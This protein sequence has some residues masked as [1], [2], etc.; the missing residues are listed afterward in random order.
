METLAAYNCAWL[1]VSLCQTLV[2]E[3]KWHL[4]FGVLPPQRVPEEK[5]MST[6]QKVTMLVGLLI[7]SY[8]SFLWLRSLAK[9]VPLRKPGTGKLR[10]LNQI[11][12]NS[13]VLRCH[14]P[15]VKKI[16]W[17]ICSS[18]GI[19]GRVSL[20][21]G[22]LAQKEQLTSLVSSFL[23][24]TD[25]SGW[26]QRLTSHCVVTSCVVS[27]YRKNKLTMPICVPCSGV[28]CSPWLDQ[29]SRFSLHACINHVSFLTLCQ[30]S[31]I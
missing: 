5:L 22:S 8:N 25:I 20:V 29:Y 26:I 11:L 17:W 16:T 21:V 10:G 19:F 2:N 7:S 30:S 13:Q 15:N 24:E 23:S 27:F 9:G 12:D 14:P 31:T 28:N 3:W 4:C 6:W 18:L 1:H